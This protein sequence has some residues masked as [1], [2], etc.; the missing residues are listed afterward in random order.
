M[1]APSAG[2]STHDQPARLRQVPAGR[3]D[4][5]EVTALGD[6]HPVGRVR[7]EVRDLLGGEGA[8]HGEG[9]RAE[10]DRGGIAEMELRPVGHE[11]RDR[12]A[13]PDAERGQPGGDAA[14]PRRVLG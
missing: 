1:N 11:Q 5:V 7:E 8:V 9:R 2:P 4:P 14:H 13:A 10:V 3:A 6:H 12:V